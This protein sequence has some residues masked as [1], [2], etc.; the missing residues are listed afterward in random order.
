MERPRDEEYAEA[1]RRGYERA[2][3]SGEP[4]VRLDRT[5]AADVPT[6]RVPAVR[7]QVPDDQAPGD[8][9]DQGAGGG[10]EPFF[11]SA[12]TL[13]EADRGPDEQGHRR[14]LTVV[15]LVLTAMV[16]VGGA[17]GIGRLFADQ[18]R[19]SA[20]P[21][22]GGP[23]A[24]TQSG[25]TDR[26][27]APAER[28]SYDGP[29]A[30]VDVATS[31]ATCQSGDS[32]DAAGNPVSYEPAKAHDADLTTAWRCD[33]SGAGARFTLT[34][35]EEMDVAEVGLVPGYAK[36]DPANG[37]DRYAENNRITRVRWHFDDGTTYVQELSGDP[38]D[39]SVRTMR[40][41]ETSSGAVGIEILASVR[42]PRNTIAISEIRIATP[43]D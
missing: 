16:L 10:R 38:A 26:G 18:A 12:T 41:P 33:G 14:A 21:S 27:E 30:A 22:D 34:L 42:G 1:F 2:R 31:E 40:I 17:F 20:G 19:T 23:E 24:Q 6:Q 43:A 29:V 36:T 28:S 11:S 13:V 3:R 8:R 25:A 35:R 32:A 15:A 5:S 9:D 37:V 39:R 4:T 7:D